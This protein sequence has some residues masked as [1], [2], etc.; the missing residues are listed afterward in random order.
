MSSDEN[1]K[2]FLKQNRPVPPQGDASRS[3][4][5]ALAQAVS[6]GIVQ[7]KP[8]SYYWMQAAAGSLFIVAASYFIQQKVAVENTVKMK[9][10]SAVEL[11]INFHEDEN[12]S[13]I[14]DLVALGS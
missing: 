6:A 11:N 4:E 5:A 9:G 14:D 2:S 13:E 8:R 10:S 3:A 1:L 12:I 7:P